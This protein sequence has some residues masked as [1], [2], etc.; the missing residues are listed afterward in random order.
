MNIVPERLEKYKAYMHKNID[1]I[2]LKTGEYKDMPTSYIIAIM[3]ATELCGEALDNGATPEQASEE[4]KEYGLSNYMVA[5]AVS[6]V[7]MYNPRG[8]E[9]QEWWNAK[10]GGKEAIKILP[11]KKRKAN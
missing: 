3:L 2:F 4:L 7:C 10:Y 8:G 1:T 11:D 9:F 5:I 6:I